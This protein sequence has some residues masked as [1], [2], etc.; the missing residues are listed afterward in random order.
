MPLQLPFVES[1][2]E[3]FDFDADNGSGSD[4]DDQNKLMWENDYCYYDF[5][6]VAVDGGDDDAKKVELMMKV[7]KKGTL[8]REKLMSDDC[9]LNPIELPL[10][11]MVS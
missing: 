3:H 6:A 10:M 1:H 11:E 7:V 8:K 5:V 4:V 2:S 9:C